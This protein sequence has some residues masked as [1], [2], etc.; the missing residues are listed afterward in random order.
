MGIGTLSHTQPP[1]RR[2]SVP[3]ESEES[4]EGTQEDSTTVPRTIL[5][6]SEALRKPFSPPGKRHR[7]EDVDLEGWEALYSQPFAKQIVEK[8][9]NRIHEEM[10]RQAEEAKDREKPQLPA[11]NVSNALVFKR[12]MARRQLLGGLL[13]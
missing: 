3:R 5:P 4:S 9:R 13:G 11:G 2:I 7:G 6:C 10:L 1:P 12:M 8:P